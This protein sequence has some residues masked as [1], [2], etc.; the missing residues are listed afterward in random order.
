MFTGYLFGFAAFRA[1]FNHSAVLHAAGGIL[2]MVC[3]MLLETVL[4][5]IRASGQDLL[6][7]NSTSKRK[8]Q[9]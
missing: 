9:Q 7:S 2:G 3:G 8:K 4:F 1:L 5:I 6:S